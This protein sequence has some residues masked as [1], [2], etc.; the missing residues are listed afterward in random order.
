MFKIN[1]ERRKFYLFQKMRQILRPSTRQNVNLLNLK[2]LKCSTYLHLK[3]SV[4][5]GPGRA[6]IFKILEMFNI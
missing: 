6:S 5:D 4:P 2:C 3:G 1:F